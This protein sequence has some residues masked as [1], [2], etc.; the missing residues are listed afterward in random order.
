MSDQTDEQNDTDSQ[1]TQVFEL[2][3]SDGQI[4]CFYGFPFVLDV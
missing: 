2:G 1:K 3:D 4:L